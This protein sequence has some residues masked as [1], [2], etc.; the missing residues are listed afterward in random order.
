MPSEVLQQIINK[1]IESMV[2]YIESG[3]Y[4]LHSEIRR[5]QYFVLGTLLAPRP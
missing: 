5:S 1:I 3:N 4:H 2:E